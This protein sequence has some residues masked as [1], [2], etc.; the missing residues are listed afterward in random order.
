M[1]PAARKETARNVLRLWQQ[2]LSY[3][4][5]TAYI[6]A[7]WERARDAEKKGNMID[8]GDLPGT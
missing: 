2:D 3:M 1:T 6:Q 4:R 8:A 7:V 5:A